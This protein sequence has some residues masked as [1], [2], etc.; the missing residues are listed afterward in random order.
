MKIKICFLCKIIFEIQV[1][2]KFVI[3][4]PTTFRIKNITTLIQQQ[5]DLISKLL[6][7]K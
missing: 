7:Q 4:N 3:L 1:Y 5:N 6:N 2:S